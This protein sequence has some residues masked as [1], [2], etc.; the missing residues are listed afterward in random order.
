[1]KTRSTTTRRPIGR[2]I[3]VFIDI[4][5]VVV[6]AIEV[7][8]ALEQDGQCCVRDWVKKFFLCMISK[9]KLEVYNAVNDV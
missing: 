3:G 7:I 8:C 1:M 4:D 9:L 5:E 6:I 2:I